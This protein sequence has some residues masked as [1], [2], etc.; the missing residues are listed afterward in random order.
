MHRLRPIVGPVRSALGQNVGPI[1]RPSSCRIALAGSP[2]LLLLLL[3]QRRYYA[4]RPTT[5][6]P[7]I[8]RQSE[9]V[10]R[11]TPTTVEFE[12][13]TYQEKTPAAAAAAVASSSSTTAVAPGLAEGKAAMLAEDTSAT[14]T[15]PTLVER[16]KSRYDRPLTLSRGP[17]QA[18]ELPTFRD[19]HRAITAFE[20]KRDLERWGRA[21]IG[22]LA[23]AT[24][25]WVGF[26]VFCENFGLAA[27]AAL[28]E[29]DVAAN[30]HDKGWGWALE[31]DDWTGGRSG[32]TSSALPLE[33]RRQ[34]H[35]AWF[36][37]FWPLG[38][39]EAELHE[40]MVQDANEAESGERSLFSRI[41]EVLGAD[42]QE[43]LGG[44][45]TD[46]QRQ[47]TLLPPIAIAEAYV[48]SAIE[49]TLADKSTTVWLPPA[50][51]S[52]DL[53]LP[54]AALHRPRIDRPAST[55]GI[56]LLIRHAVLLE[57]MATDE[58]LE[59]ARA[60]FERVLR[61]IN[62]FKG[63][64]T[65][66][67][68]LARRLGDLGRATG[69]PRADAWLRWGVERVT[70]YRPTD[71][72]DGSLA[73]LQA[74]RGTPS[75]R[76]SW[77]PLSWASAKAAK[78]AP[79]ADNA[80]S[81]ADASSSSSSSIA[82]LL[83]LRRTESIPPARQ[84]ALLSLVASLSAVQSRPDTLTAARETQ[85][86]ALDFIAA[87]TVRLPDPA[88]MSAVASRQLHQL[89]LERYRALFSTHLAEVLY[90]SDLAAAGGRT[91][92]SLLDSAFQQAVAVAD[93]LAPP[94]PP[95]PPSSEAD[96]ISSP[97]SFPLPML[98]T[99]VEGQAH[100]L[101]RSPT[102][103]PFAPTRQPG[104]L[105]RPAADLLSNAR[106]TAAT[107]ANLLAFL[108]L[109][110]KLPGGQPTYQDLVEAKGLCTAA[111]TLV[112][113]LPPVA[114]SGDRVVV[115]SPSTGEEESVDQ[116]SADWQKYYARLRTITNQLREV[117]S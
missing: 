13:E 65:L 82:A 10:G 70:G 41:R 40:Q 29:D 84:R 58:S 32:G 62:G 92:A 54:P 86:A 89:A 106:R 6:Q 38:S 4:S 31:N 59:R 71:D 68:Q 116:Q 60:L 9:D 37:L 8:Q 24:S 48:R 93:A 63:A 101:A 28:W 75:Q 11:S 18:I 73:A 20:L 77:W 51:V 52:D 17:H 39:T 45:L 42:S 72:D 3:P 100:P 69:D 112:G 50:L 16:L 110:P 78:D 94:P 99:V 98:T 56:T 46:G 35:M 115:I 91:T 105:E 12:P 114:E 55:V 34:L 79:P 76:H 21:I 1:A 47:L 2:P 14:M 22:A 95:P 30:D 53:P 104:V 67:A 97:P 66:E 7:Q 61:A 27:P 64:E 108:A 81:A 33:A 109:R 102:V 74:S 57:Q 107:A 96:G 36:A 111:L 44:L 90:V 19:G 88:S 117:A 85:S 5:V 23:F 103:P 87:A 43:T 83:A 25:V 15:A 113:P 26:F 80:L 49:E